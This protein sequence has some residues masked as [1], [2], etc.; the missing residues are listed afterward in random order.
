MGTELPFRLMHP[1]PEEKNP[2]GQF[3]LVSA[4]LCPQTPVKSY[5]CKAYGDVFYRKPSE[6]AKLQHGGCSV[7]VYR[8]VCVCVCVYQH[9]I[10]G[11][12]AAKMG[13]GGNGRVPLVPFIYGFTT[14][15]A[16]A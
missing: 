9:K 12:I 2:A 4:F 11:R 15:S 5:H 8:Y 14:Q 10:T 13:E 3:R 1:K 16:G 6:F 7:A